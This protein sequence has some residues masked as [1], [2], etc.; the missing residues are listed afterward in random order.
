MQPDTIRMAGTYAIAIMVLIGSWSLLVF[1]S[2]VPSEQLLPFITGITG[3]VIGWAFNRE[4]TTAG[5]RQSER[6]VTVG[7][8][9]ATNPPPPMNQ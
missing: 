3:A 9:A 7:A 2:Q 6:S 1:P 4:S 5:A 8:Q